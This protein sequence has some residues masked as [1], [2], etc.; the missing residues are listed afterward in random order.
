MSKSNKEYWEDFLNRYRLSKTIRVLRNKISMKEIAELTD[1][2][3][4]YIYGIQEMAIKPSEE[5][6]TKLSEVI[7]GQK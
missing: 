5:F 3:K 2:S 6:L 7:N 1:Q 4:Q